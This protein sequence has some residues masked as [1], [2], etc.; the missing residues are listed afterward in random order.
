MKA[1]PRG[2]DPFAPRLGDLSEGRDN[3]VNLIRLCASI[4]VLVSHAWPIS[5]GPGTAEP[6]SRLAGH[7]IGT[8]AVF[9]FFALSGFFIAGSFSRNPQAGRFIIL[10]IG[11][12]FPALVVSITLVGLIL[13]PII[14][15]LPPGAF[16]THPDTASFLWRNITLIRPQYDLPGVFTTNPYPMIEGSIW[17]LFY[18]VVCYGAV[19]VLGCLG[20]LKSRVRMIAVLILYGIIWSISGFYADGLHPTLSHLRDLSLPFM[21]GV[22]FWI[23]RSGIVLSLRGLALFSG[24][25]WLAAPTALFD[26]LLILALAYGTFWLGYV[27]R[28]Q[29]KAFNRLGDYSYGV[30]IYAFPLQGWVIWYWGAMTP[31]MNIALSLPPVILCAVLSWHFIERPALMK[32]RAVR[33]SSK[34]AIQSW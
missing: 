8:L 5:L 10:R 29:A 14:S 6:L 11:R 7:S 12:L 28:G 2:P 18:E 3:N 23:W 15:D 4:A 21:I 25:A 1:Q 13:A 34:Q 22:G 9:V 24:L 20:L 17:T 30:Y 26:P 31:A 27:P 19:L 33:L 16:L 32:A